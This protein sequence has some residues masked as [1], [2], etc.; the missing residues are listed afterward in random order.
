MWPIELCYLQWK[1]STY[2]VILAILTKN[3][4]SQVFRSLIDSPGDL[5]KG[6][7]CQWP[8]MIFKSQISY[9]KCLRCLYLNKNLAIA[10]RSRVSCAHNTSRASIVTPL[11]WNRSRSNGTIF[12][13][14]EWSCQD[15]S[16]SLKMVP[17]ESLG[18]ASYSHSM[19]T[20]AVSLAVSGILSVK[21]WPDLEIWVWVVQ[22]HWKWCRSIDHIRFSIG[23]PL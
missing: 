15:H 21:E 17:F 22:S 1:W 9:C 14:L 5:I 23:R 4:C 2:K 20:I 7:N 3:K 13:D 6:D 11:P 16:R 12:N 18:S 10:N 19:V 8:W